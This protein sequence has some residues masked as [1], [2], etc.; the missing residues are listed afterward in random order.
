MM[1]WKNADSEQTAGWISYRLDPND[2]AA[3]G[4]DW[5]KC[6]DIRA[7]MAGPHNWRLRDFTNDTV[8]EMVFDTKVKIQ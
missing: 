2:P 5:C 8:S 4:D 1:Q 6:E 7:V 3:P